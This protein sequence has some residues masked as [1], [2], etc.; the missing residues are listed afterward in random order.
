[1]QTSNAGGGDATNSSHS[2]G[3]TRK[4][5]LTP[6]T[7]YVLNEKLST[8]PVDD[9]SE[10]KRVYKCGVCP[11]KCTALA[12]LVIH[13]E[14]KHKSGKYGGPCGLHCDVILL[15]VNLLYTSYV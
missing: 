13:V 1:M 4:Q 2:K 12:A 11:I 15:P 3:S 6:K 9:G 14:N 5:D 7:E 8:K 10:E